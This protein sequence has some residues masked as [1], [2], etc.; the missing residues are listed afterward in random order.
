MYNALTTSSAIR[1]NYFPFPHTHIYHTYIIS[2]IRIWKSPKQ[3][4]HIYHVYFKCMT[5]A[6][7]LIQLA[8]KLF[9]SSHTQQATLPVL[10]TTG[11][12]SWLQLAQCRGYNKV[13]LSFWMSSWV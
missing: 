6:D 11:S 13:Y 9:L 12:M 5:C 4:Y 1:T 2:I 10:T 3:T 8:S 7:N